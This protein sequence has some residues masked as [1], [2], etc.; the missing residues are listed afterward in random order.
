MAKVC[1]QPCEFTNN[2]GVSLQIEPGDICLISLHSMHHDEE[3]FPQPEEFMPERFAEE[4]G[5]TKKYK[6]MGVYLPFGDGPRICLGL[7]C[8]HISH[9]LAHFV[10]ATFYVCC[11]NFVSCWVFGDCN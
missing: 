11:V 9:V 3:F 5:G 6:D 7:Y 2:D 10:F 4:N 8:S 1:T